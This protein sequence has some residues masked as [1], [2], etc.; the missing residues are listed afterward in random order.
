MQQHISRVLEKKYVYTL[1]RN[2][3]HLTKIESGVWK[4]KKMKNPK[5]ELP[6]I[7]VALIRI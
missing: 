2:E 6:S 7:H 1:D 5:K 4:E 3:T